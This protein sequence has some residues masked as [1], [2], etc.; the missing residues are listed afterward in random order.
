MPTIWQPPKLATPLAA[1]W[2]RPPVQVR[3]APLPG[4]E[5]MA[6]V[7]EAPELV[8]VLPP[9]SSTVTT[10]WVVQAAPLAPPP[11]EVVKTSWVAAPTP[12]LNELLVAVPS[13]VAVALRE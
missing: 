3:D 13:P 4:C 6:K 1:A 10:G 2:L 8:T 7:T 11:G 5:A 12:M 9:L